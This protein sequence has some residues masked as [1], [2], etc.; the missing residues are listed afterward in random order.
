MK[1][2]SAFSIILLIL[3]VP[4]CVFVANI[5]SNV[6]LL[7]YSYS[8][9]ETQKAIVYS[10]SL[11]EDEKEDN[12]QKLKQEV[13]KQNGA[14]YVLKFQ[15][16]FYL[17]ASVY[18]NET[19]AEK[20][21]KN[22]KNNNVDAEVLKIEIPNYVLNGNFSSKEKEVLSNAG[23][24]GLEI[25]KSLYDVAVSLDT[26]VTTE[27]DAKLSCNQ[28]YS[29]FVSIKT[30]FSTLFKNSKKTDNIATK[31]EQIE[32]TLKNLIDEKKEENQTFSSLI[33]L[34]YCKILFEN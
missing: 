30:N 20:V 6:F 8:D 1:K 24:C 29:N 5:L 32:K 10:I 22:L 34:S 17:I 18:E 28:I 14:G 16:K 26:N 19:D 27:N 7:C 15:D 2:F 13:Q 33:K 4:V 3:F 25:F 12:V 23:N 31:L 11:Y 9:F 21:K